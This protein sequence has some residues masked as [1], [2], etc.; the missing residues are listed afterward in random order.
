MSAPAATVIVTAVTDDVSAPPIPYVPAVDAE[1]VPKCVAAVVPGVVN[2]SAEEFVLDPPEAAFHEHACRVTDAISF[3]PVVDGE[4]VC[5]CTYAIRFVGVPE[6]SPPLSAWLQN[7]V[8]ASAMTQ[9]FRFLP[10]ARWW[11][12][13]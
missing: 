2:V 5:I 8:D 10:W 4:A 7:E 12:S 1:N 13:S 3:A 9:P 6:A 11:E